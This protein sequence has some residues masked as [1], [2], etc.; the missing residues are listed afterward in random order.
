MQTHKEENG[1]A[2]ARCPSFSDTKRGGREA[3][4][5]GRTG[6]AGGRGHHGSWSVGDVEART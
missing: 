6:P 3:A 5:R 4:K 2:S 1:V